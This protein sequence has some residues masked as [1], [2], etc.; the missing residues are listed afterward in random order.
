MR[1]VREETG[2]QLEAEPTFLGTDE[3]LDALGRPAVS[4]F[5]RVDAPHGVRDSWEHVV[6][7][8]EDDAGLVFLCRFDATP[9]LWPAQTVYRT[10]LSSFRIEDQPRASVRARFDG[11]S[12]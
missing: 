12:C 3:H 7:G 10:Y 11:V 4:Y 5:F 1:E 9:V 2:L 6:A 8:D